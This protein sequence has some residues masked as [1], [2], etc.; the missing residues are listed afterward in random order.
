MYTELTSQAHMYVCI[1][2]YCIHVYMYA[3]LTSQAHMYVYMYTCT[4]VC[5]ICFMY[6][7]YAWIH[8]CMHEY[9][10]TYDLCTCMYGCAQTY[11]YV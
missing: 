10:H 1:H 5:M 3:E 8:V 6:D 4:H 9:I 2:V 7:A 11:M